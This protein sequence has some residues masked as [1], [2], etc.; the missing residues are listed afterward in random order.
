[1]TDAS[2]D[3]RLIPPHNLPPELPALQVLETV[4]YQVSL[5][6]DLLDEAQLVALRRRTNDDLLRLRPAVFQH[7]RNQARLV[8]TPHQQ[9]AQCRHRRHAIG[10]AWRSD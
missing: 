2:T 1:M 4:D 8:D 9:K 5:F 7:F 10:R 6:D 3:A